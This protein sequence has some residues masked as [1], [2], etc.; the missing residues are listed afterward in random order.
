MI[1]RPSDLLTNLKES[2][3]ELDSHTNTCV[4]GR[5]C[6]IVQEFHWYISVTIY[7][8]ALD[9]QN[10]RQPVT[11]AL[12]HDFPDNGEAIMLIIHQ[13]L[14]IETM[15]NNLLCPMQIRMAGIVANNQPKFLAH[16]PTANDH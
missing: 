7:D 5:N 4:V 8:P 9:S 14:L 3:T 6:L 2:S 16:K 10:E 12:A 11:A 1:K 13:A 15:K